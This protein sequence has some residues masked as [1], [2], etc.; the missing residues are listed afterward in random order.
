MIG[1]FISCRQWVF[2]SVLGSVKFLDGLQIWLEKIKPP[3]A[4]EHFLVGH[5]LRTKDPW[6]LEPP[7]TSLSSWTPP[8]PRHRDQLHITVCAELFVEPAGD[9]QA[10]EA[11]APWHSPVGWQG[12]FAGPC[13]S[14][15]GSIPALLLPVLLCGS[16]TS[17]HRQFCLANIPSQVCRFQS[18][19][20]LGL[21]GMERE[22]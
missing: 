7:W 17:T 19:H 10:R 6:P 15:P 16:G 8:S 18:S 21:G 2:S 4:L 14:L 11:E 22:T 5:L 20:D 1:T 13:L 3:K 9:W 12:S